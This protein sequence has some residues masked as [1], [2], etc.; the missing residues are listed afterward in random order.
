ME[1]VGM[2]FVS[3]A[4]HPLKQT[5]DILYMRSDYITKTMLYIR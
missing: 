4:T 3:I 2:G 1:A 5:L